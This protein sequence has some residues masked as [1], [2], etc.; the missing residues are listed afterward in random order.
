MAEAEKLIKWGLIGG[1]AVF[2]GYLV[3]R[4]LSTQGIIGLAQ[5]QAEQTQRVST[6]GV[7][8][9]YRSRPTYQLGNS[10]SVREINR[11]AENHWRGRAVT[12]QTWFGLAH[13]SILPQELT[14]TFN[15]PT[16]GLS[17]P[18]EGPHVSPEIEAAI[19]RSEQRR[20]W[21]GGGQKAPVEGT[22]G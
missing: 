8:Q 1:V 7:N 3:Y 18:E 17:Y 2:G 5:P 14:G 19:A 10:G 13:G 4:A 12:P 16:L 22:F 6:G 15:G 9:T 20:T 21:F 11:V